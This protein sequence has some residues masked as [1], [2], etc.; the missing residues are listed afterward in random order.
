MFFG[1]TVLLATSSLSRLVLMLRGMRHELLS[2]KVVM[3][4]SPTINAGLSQSDGHS[5][6]WSGARPA[7]GSS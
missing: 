3:Y 2:S 1:G 5:S 4:T 6:I 7:S